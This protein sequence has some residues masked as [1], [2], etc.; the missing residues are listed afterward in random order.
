MR[1]FLGPLLPALVVAL[2]VGGG[3]AMPFGL[4]PGTHAEPP[5][6]EYRG[7][8]MAPG[9]KLV[10]LDSLEA[11]DRYCRERGMSPNEAFRRVLIEAC[12]LDGDREKVMPKA[13]V[14][15]DARYR[16]LDEHENGHTWGL[17][18]GSGGRG[19][20]RS[21]G[22][23]RKNPHIVDEAMVGKAPPLRTRQAPA[24]GMFK[25]R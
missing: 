5:P 22:F 20:E 2:I 4:R 17:T 12:V 9:F 10:E 11:V 23:F 19:W 13:G 7:R 14:L 15:D 18:H 24:E 8:G 25:P 21:E 6:K 3:F 1:G 16:A